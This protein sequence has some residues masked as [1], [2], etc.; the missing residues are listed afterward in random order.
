MAHQEHVEIINQGVEAWNHW[1]QEIRQGGGAPITPDLSGVVL[2][3]ANLSKIDL[4]S[5][6]LRGAILSDANL[7]SA[8]LGHANLTGIMTHLDGANLCN[9]DLTHADFS[10]AVL[11]RANL[12][13]AIS[14]GARF[15]EAHLTGANFYNASLEGA[16]FKRA[17]LTN[18]N[19]TKAQLSGADL[20][21]AHLENA[22]LVETD[23]SKANLD[24]CTVF[25]VSAWGVKLDGATQTNLRITGD[26][27]P[28]VTVGDLEIA[29]FIYLIL[30]H[31]KIRS[32][33]KT[34]GERAV[35]LLGRFTP[36]R[37]EI[38]DAIAGKLR[39]L[40]Y[41]PILFDFEKVPGRDYTETVMILAG[42]S[43][44]VIADITQPKSVPQEAQAII[45][46][47]KIPFV[48]VIQE[49]EQPWSMSV[50]FQSS[51]RIIGPIQYPNK[52]TLAANLTR[53][54][55]R[56]EEKH[57]Q[58]VEQKAAAAPEII[59]IDKLPS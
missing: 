2:E 28:A 18:A 17:Y 16:E 4:E 56:A 13:V 37:K 32:A 1:R 43:K 12:T 44:F 22:L 10:G 42:L 55:N 51:N 45:P 19:L 24:G 3:G 53:I 20:A 59:S 15:N 21:G 49:G 41:L 9:A 31:K 26:N 34:M 40:K 47:F 50:D 6:D 30:N 57:A 52:E 38:L 14:Y 35:L 33:I 29:Q 27:E 46:N 39:E 7:F 54:V 23:L 8:K 5:A 58:L 11:D 36:E 48:Q 25:G